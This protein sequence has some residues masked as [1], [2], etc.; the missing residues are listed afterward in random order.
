MLPSPP[1]PT[2]RYPP[3]YLRIAARYSLS[4][5]TVTDLVSVLLAAVGSPAG[6]VI[7]LVI[8]SCVLTAT[9]LSTLAV[10]TIKPLVPFGS[11][12]TLQVS[13]PL[14]PPL[15]LASGDSSL[16]SVTPAG[17]T[18]VMIASLVSFWPAF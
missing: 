10:T 3:A 2:I 17:N 6:T 5:P 12:E 9:V 16:T 14:V 11:D 15:K 8:D 18:L 4:R 1:H 13:E 7:L